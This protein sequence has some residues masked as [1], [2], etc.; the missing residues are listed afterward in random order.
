[1]HVREIRPEDVDA[2]VERVGRALADDASLNP[3]VAAHVD[4]ATL[5]H[6][7]RAN[8]GATLVALEDGVVVGHLYGVILDDARGRDAWTGPDGWSGDERAMSA[9]RAAAV[10]AWRLAR[11]AHHHA[12]VL[13]EESR[14]R[15]WTNAGY[16]AEEVRGLRSLEGATGLANASVRWLDGGDLDVA[17][18]FDEMIDLAHGLTSE[19]VRARRRALRAL[20]D[21]DDVSHVVLEENGRVLAQCITFA[22]APT[23]ATPEATLHV[24]ALAVAPE[25]RRRGLARTLVECVF[26]DARARGFSHAHVTWRRTNAPA[27]AFWHAMGFQRTYVR[28]RAAIS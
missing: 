26:Y 18:D 16:R 5:A 24:S 15:P 17:L 3:L 27:D 23:R 11:V 19:P 25:A 6:S 14:M 22:L 28:L 10:D 4:S 1:M 20:F 2:V 9:L 7:L 13:D 21:D 12:W 8:P